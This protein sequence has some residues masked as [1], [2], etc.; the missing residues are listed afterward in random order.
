MKIDFRRSGILTLALSYF[1]SLQ[2]AEAQ[3]IGVEQE[4]EAQA[5]APIM[6]MT[7]AQYEEEAIALATWKSKVQGSYMGDKL[8]HFLT[9]LDANL[10]RNP[11]DCI[12]LY[13]RGYLFGT[14][15]C[16]K[17]AIIDLSKA[18]QVEPLSAHLYCERGICY[19]DLGDYSNAL[20]DLGKAISYDANSG[21]ARLAR[22]RL[23][24][25]LG[26]PL[27]A[28][29]DLQ[30]CKKSTLVFSTVLPG[31]VPGNKFRAPDYYL[32]VCYEMLGQH[33]EAVSHFLLSAPD[34]EDDNAGGYLHRYADRPLDGEER[35]NKLR[36]G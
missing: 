4:A 29:S 2:T 3:E 25:T 15:G 13:N 31:E 30:E 18:I 19:M 17:A 14:V 8:I 11:R 27:E 7:K 12:S 20:R 24:L 22:G 6:K 36:N 23:L 5:D 28:L 33:D 21:D 26:R 35:A 34:S 10:V 9:T 32:G 16:T 1:L